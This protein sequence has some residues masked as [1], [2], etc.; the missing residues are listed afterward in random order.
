MIF[1]LG[2]GGLGNIFTGE[3]FSLE[4]KKDPLQRNLQNS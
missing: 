2:G 4:L 3:Y 1:F